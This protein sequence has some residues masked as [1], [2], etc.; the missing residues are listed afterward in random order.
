MIIVRA[1]DSMLR[2]GYF[3]P[4]WRRNDAERFVEEVKARSDLAEDVDA[5]E[6]ISVR[7]P[8]DL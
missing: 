1:K 8:D 4:F 6:I 5:I 2:N 3:G 7:T